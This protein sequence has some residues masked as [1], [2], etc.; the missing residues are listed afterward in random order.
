MKLGQIHLFGEMDLNLGNNV[1]S[2]YK[3]A[4]HISE[5]CGYVTHLEKG[6][7]DKSR[8]RIEIFGEDCDDRLSVV[9]VIYFKGQKIQ[10]VKKCVYKIGYDNNRL[11]KQLTQVYDF[12]N[13][14]FIETFNARRLKLDMNKE[15]EDET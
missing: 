11:F 15:F 13:G 3:K 4:C 14:E 5:C 10:D 6:I 7:K 8:D 1:K 12:V 9:N 2:V